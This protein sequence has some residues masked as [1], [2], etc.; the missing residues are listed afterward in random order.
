MTVNTNYITN[1]AG[2]ALMTL[3]AVSAVGDIIRLTNQNAAG[4]FRVRQPAGVTIFFDQLATTT[5][6]AG[7][8]QVTN[9]GARASIELVC[10]TANTDWNVLSSIGA[11][12]I[13]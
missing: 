10:V 11:F 12:T 8:V 4:T 3:P 7:Y 1:V 9:A 5:G 13:V 2:N 6:I